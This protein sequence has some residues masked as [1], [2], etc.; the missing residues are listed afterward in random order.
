MADQA[1]PPGAGTRQLLPRPSCASPGRSGPSPRPRSIERCPRSAPAG[2]RSP[3][4]GFAT[5]TGGRGRAG[6]QRKGRPRPPGGAAGEG[7][8]ARARSGGARNRAM[9]SGLRKGQAVRQA[10][11]GR[12]ERRGT[13][14]RRRAGTCAVALRSGAV[15]SGRGGAG[16]EEG[17]CGFPVKH[18]GGRSRASGPPP[19][20]PLAPCLQVGLWVGLQNNFDVPSPG[21][22]VG[23]TT[24]I[25][26][27][28]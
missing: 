24:C 21:V 13:A 26:V 7:A 14:G 22:A 5:A 2:A 19:C 1:G 6:G 20:P 3:G 25:S 28:V 15:G 11:G 8:A 12:P 23:P 9:G 10:P 16:V 4:A 18:P 17:R 27:L